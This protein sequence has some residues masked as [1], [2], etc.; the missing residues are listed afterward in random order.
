MQ[1]L[2]M[3][4]LSPRGAIKDESLEII[5][6]GGILIEDQRI[7]QVDTFDKLFRDFEGSDLK[8]YELKIPCVLLPGFVDAHTH[9]CYGGDRRI[10][11]AARIN[12]ATYQEIASAGG[13]IWSSVQA[14]RQASVQELKESLNLR[15]NELLKQGITTIEVKSGYGL[16]VDAELK[17]LQAIGEVQSESVADLITTCLAAHVLP[18][19]FNGDNEDYLTHL[20]RELL[21]LVKNEEL[22]NRIDIFV[23]DLAFGLNE[24][25]VYLQKCKELGFDITIHGDQFSEG[26]TQLAI[27]MNARSVDHLECVS[28]AKIQQLAQS[29]V[30]GIVLPGASLGLGM[31]FA[32]ARKML[33]LGCKMAIAS[34]TNPGSAPMG[35]LLI[36][37]SI[38]SA[39]EKLSSAEVF[40]GITFRASAALGLNDRGVLKPGQ[41]AD[42]LAFPTNDYRSILYHQG[43]LK[44]SHVWKS[45]ILI[46]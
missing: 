28:P 44:P 7:V 21:P 19:D 20:I 26:G 42:L 9:L 2:T 14:T 17:T 16:S 24:S 41:F 34:D 29:N 40:A 22:A 37:A 13:G 15:I 27:E 3:D 32:P 1:I 31:Q 25:K 30:T 23:D 10:D 5:H 4:H 8:I 11:Y 6:Q 39:Y 33:D 35:D 18:R 43:T 46:K 36:Q 45:G 38:L 12:G